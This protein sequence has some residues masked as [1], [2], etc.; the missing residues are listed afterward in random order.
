MIS[1]SSRYEATPQACV[2]SP[3]RADPTGRDLCHFL[4]RGSFSLAA[5][6]EVLDQLERADALRTRMLDAVKGLAESL[7][8]WLEAAR[9]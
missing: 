3:V 6:G 1:A 9:T 5:L 2:T 4:P 8:R 7:E